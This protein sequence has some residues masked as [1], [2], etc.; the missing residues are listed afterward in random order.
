MPVGELA[1]CV[2]G[3]DSMIAE[4]PVAS[5]RPRFETMNYFEG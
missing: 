4:L 3:V 2:C 1:D 5:E